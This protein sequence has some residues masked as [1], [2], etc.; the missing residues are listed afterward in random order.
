MKLLI[1][2]NTYEE[3]ES[4]LLKSMIEIIDKPMFF[5][6]IEGVYKICNQAYC[7][8]LGL[9]YDQIIGKNMD[10]VIP[11]ELYDT[12]KK[13]DDELISNKN[14]QQFERK[15]LMHDD[16]LHDIV[17][18][19]NIYHDNFGQCRGIIGVLEDVTE[20]KLNMKKIEKREMIKDLFLNLNNN[21][22]HNLENMDIFDHL[23]KGLVDIFDD[24]D[25][26]SVLKIDNR[27][28]LKSI[29]SVGYIEKSIE[30][31]ELNLKDSFI[32]QYS[33]G[34]IDNPKILKN[35]TD[36]K[37]DRCPDIPETVDGNTVQSMMFI[38][39]SD[40]NN[41]QWYICLDSNMPNAFNEFD[42]K[43]AEYV[44]FQ[45]PIL[46]RIFKL[47]HERLEISRYDELTGLINR[48]Y[49]TELLK[50]KIRYVK[51]HKLQLV[52]I[53][54]DL[55]NLKAVNDVFGHQKGDAY[56]KF[57]S[58]EIKK[59]FRTDD[60]IARIGGDEFVGIFVTDD[61]AEIELTIN[62]FQNKFGKKKIKFNNS[63]FKVNFSYGVAV[64]PNECSNTEELIKM[65]DER[66][67]RDKFSKK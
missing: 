52:M 19:K 53:M 43:I 55:D 30:M 34:M 65:A 48:R 36:V 8:F 2:E 32:Y 12:F 58:S 22:G 51:N 29:S 17:F 64:Y 15:I 25:Y 33:M 42:L 39:I 40:S 6:D 1:G 13:A 37:F 61:S 46:N 45:V 11:H 56:L 59:F 7:D 57:F 66:M 21:L 62:K 26:G 49:F 35:L 20:E 16:E 50:E 31:F 47:N 9:E 67:Y 60:I 4:L 63:K 18:K 3:S 28:K 14:M 5:K 10:E 23:I 41:E 27:N 54:I 38:P 44:M 24:A